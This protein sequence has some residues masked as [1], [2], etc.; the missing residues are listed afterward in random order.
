MPKPK[1]RKVVVGNAAKFLLTL[2]IDRAGKERSHEREVHSESSREVSHTLRFFSNK[3]AHNI[4]LIAGGAFAGTLLQ[5]E[6]RRIGEIFHGGPSRHLC[7]QALQALGLAQTG[8]G[9]FC[10]KAAQIQRHRTD[11]ARCFVGC[12]FLLAHYAVRLK[13]YAEVRLILLLYKDTNL[14][15]DT[16]F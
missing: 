16:K 13:G 2:H 11:A 3:P 9:R 7:R 8:I 4:G 15:K 5:R 6:A 1:Q 14:C 10:R 12:V